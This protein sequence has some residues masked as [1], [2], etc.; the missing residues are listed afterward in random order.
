MCACAYVYSKTYVVS[1]FP[2]PLVVPRELRWAGRRT[3]T[4][5]LKPDTTYEETISELDTV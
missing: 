1:A 4:V 2:P 3:V 5:R